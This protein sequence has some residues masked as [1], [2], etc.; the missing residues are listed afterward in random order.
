LTAF[1]IIPRTMLMSCVLVCVNEREKER[2][3]E[4]ERET[5]RDKILRDRK[6]EG[7]DRWIYKCRE[8]EVGKDIKI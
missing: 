8:R 3:K 2:K 1:N 6:R 7:E 4:R 5:R